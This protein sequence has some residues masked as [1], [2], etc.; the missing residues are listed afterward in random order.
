MSGPGDRVAD[1]ADR[2]LL[3]RQI[4]V[5]TLVA[6]RHAVRE[7]C[8]AAGLD[9]ERLYRFVTAVNEIATNA[10]RHGGGRGRLRLRADGG[11]VACEVSDDGPGLPTGGPAQWA[12]PAT[13]TIGGWGLWLARQNCDEVSVDTGPGG[14]TITLCMS[15][16]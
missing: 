16:R 15:A 13:G 5:D 2:W 14:T 10:V 9:G 11:R 8:A 6:V 1:V 4:T 12:R 3:S 7:H